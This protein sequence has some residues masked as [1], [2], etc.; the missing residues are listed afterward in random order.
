MPN[1]DTN[2]PNSNLQFGNVQGNVVVPQ[3][4]GNLAGDVVGRDKNVTIIRSLTIYLSSRPAEPEPQPVAADIG[5]NPYKGLSAF[6]ETDAFARALN[7]AR[8]SPPGSH[9]GFPRH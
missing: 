5:P 6:Q 7:Q 2:M 3:V 8:R 9:R 4:G 1:S